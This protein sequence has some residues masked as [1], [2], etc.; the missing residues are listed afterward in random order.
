MKVNHS[1]TSLI[2]VPSG[3]DLSGAPAP[4]GAAMTWVRAAL[5]MML[6]QLDP[7]PPP[8][9]VGVAEASAATTEVARVEEAPPTAGAVWV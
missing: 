5:G 7:M 3:R 4:V 9:R 1:N 8:M 6:V 2:L